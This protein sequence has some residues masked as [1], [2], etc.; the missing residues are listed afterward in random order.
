MIAWLFRAFLLAELLALAG[1]G[2]F[3]SRN[4]VEPEGIALVLVMAVVAWRISHGLV[5]WCVAQ[6]W[7]LAKG[8]APDWTNQIVA[9]I[10]EIGARLV[11]FNWSQPF[12]SLAMRGDPAGVREGTPILLVHGFFSNRGIWHAMRRRLVYARLGPVYLMELSPVFGRVPDM[13][14]SLEARIESICRETGAERVH[15][16]AH[17]MGGLVSREVLRRQGGRRVAR[18]ITLGSPHR[19]TTIA[20]FAPFPCVKDMQRG[21]DFLTRLEQAEAANPPAVKTTSIYSRNDDLVFPSETS[22]LP[23]ADNVELNGVGHVSLLFS[24]DAALRV[25]ALLRHSASRGKT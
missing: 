23:W 13:A 19:G 22:R 4:V 1:L 21:G 9:L 6:A 8:R 12:P 20:A 14:A 5:T 18:L 3:L 17:S 7:R 25:I 16:V 15:L 11:S 10:K 2:A 24:R